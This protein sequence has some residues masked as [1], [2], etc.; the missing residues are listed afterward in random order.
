MSTGVLKVTGRCES[1]RETTVRALSL[2]ENLPLH[3]ILAWTAP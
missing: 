3:R 1:G 2:D